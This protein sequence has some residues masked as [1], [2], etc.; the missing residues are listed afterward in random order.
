MDEILLQSA[1]ST[2]LNFRQVGPLTVFVHVDELT[3]RS[4]SIGASRDTRPQPLIKARPHAVIAMEN[5][6]PVPC[7]M[8]DAVVEVADE[9]NIL[10]LPAKGD[11]SAADL[12]HHRVRIVDRR[13]VVDYLD[14]HLG[15][16]GVL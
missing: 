8:A 15:W 10:G 7:G 14:L 16:A 2:R 5:M 4:T 11:A 12:A 6:N 1:R 9:A 13:A 3:E